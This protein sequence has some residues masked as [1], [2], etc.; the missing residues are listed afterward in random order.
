MVLCGA[1]AYEQKYYL[2]QEFSGLPTQIKEEL[3]IMCVLYTEEIGG[4][5]T[6]EF[7]DEDGTL[8]LKTNSEEND[9]AYDEIGAE[10]KIRQLMREKQELFKSLE[11]YYKIFVDGDIPEEL[12][13]ESEN[14]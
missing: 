9:F 12:L 10:L 7:D 1:N 3:Q 5:F 8:L 13:K 11:L 14:A 2:N 6:V 4:I